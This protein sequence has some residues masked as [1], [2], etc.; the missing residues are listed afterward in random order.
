MSRSL[1][2][3]ELLKVDQS[4]VV[5]VYFDYPSN[6]TQ[7]GTNIT[8]SLLKQL[9]SQLEDI[10]LEIESYYNESKHT[11]PSRDTLVRYLTLCSRKFSKLYAVFDAIDESSE[12]NQNEILTLF[13]DLQKLG[14][15]ILVSGRPGSAFS[16]L[17]CG[18]THPRVLEIRADDSD[19][20]QYVLSRVKEGIIQKK[21]LKL[22]ER[23]DGT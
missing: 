4:K 11:R 17:Q 10:P 12:V 19:L 7:T 20:K 6:R 22:V 18:L 8:A 15:K 13:A 21:C 1:A 16:K 5:Y 3:D 2:V 9:L 23:V 14:Y